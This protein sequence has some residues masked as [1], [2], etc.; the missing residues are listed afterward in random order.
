LAP[1]TQPAD[2]AAP[3]TWTQPIR[4]AIGAVNNLEIGTTGKY[5]DVLAR[6]LSSLGYLLADTFTRPDSSSPGNAETG[7]VWTLSS[8]AAFA[9]SGNQLI[10]STAGTLYTDLGRIDCELFAPISAQTGASPGVVF[11]GSA[12]GTARLSVHIDMS[13]G[14]RLNKVFSSVTT[15]L[16]TIPQTFTAGTLYFVR[17]VILGN[18]IYGYLNGQLLII[19]TLAGGDE[20]TFATNTNVGLRN[21]GSGSVFDAFT[22]RV[23]YPVATGSN[24]IPVGYEVVYIATGTDADLA[25][26]LGSVPPGANLV[27]VRKA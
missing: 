6:A 7:Q 10:T 16:V 3:Y 12:D 15:P 27:A 25:T 5:G 11:R 8:G 23:A 21:F 9:V 20:T 4:D 19:H 2:N 1:I 26:A 22:V 14:F 13:N 18:V 17:V 24:A